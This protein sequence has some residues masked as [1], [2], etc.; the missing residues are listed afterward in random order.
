MIQVLS[1]VNPV[2]NSI[3]RLHYRAFNDLEKVI[4]DSLGKVLQ[5]DENSK[6]IHSRA[7]M[8]I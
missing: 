7:M 3:W 4:V 1:L 2:W 8:Y 6:K 5:I